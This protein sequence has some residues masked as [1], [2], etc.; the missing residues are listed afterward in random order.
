LA[1]KA[2]FLH[3]SQNSSKLNFMGY[4]PQL[5]SIVGSEKNM[6]LSIVGDV[7]VQMIHME[8]VRWLLRKEVAQQLS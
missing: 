3:Q 2:Y 8:D 5:H 7:P 1:I 4:F 6:H